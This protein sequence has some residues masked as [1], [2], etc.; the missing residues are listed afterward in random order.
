MHPHWNQ[1]H[2][3]C[4]WCGHGPVADDPEFRS[5]DFCYIT[6]LSLLDAQKIISHG[7]SR[8]IWEDNT[9]FELAFMTQRD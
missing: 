3:L 2:P 7:G 9:I 6:I 5:C 8:R 1:M 4:S